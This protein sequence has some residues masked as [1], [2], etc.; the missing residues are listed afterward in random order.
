MVWKAVLQIA[1]TSPGGT[2]APGKPDF[3]PSRCD[4]LQLLMK[5]ST[6]CYYNTYTFL[7][8]TYENRCSCLT[9]NQIS[10]TCLKWYRGSPGSPAEACLIAIL[11]RTFRWKHL[12]T[13]P[14]ASCNAKASMPSSSKLLW[15]VGHFGTSP[16]GCSHVEATLPAPSSLVFLFG[17]KPERNPTPWDVS[18]PD[19]TERSSTT[20]P[21]ALPPAKMSFCF[22]QQG[23]GCCFTAQQGIWRDQ[24]LTR[25]KNSRVL[26]KESTAD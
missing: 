13:E 15:G 21:P 1:H 5:P 4:A 8:T 17:V 2:G 26:S 10:L 6:V 24:Q 20:A 7:L 9:L 22:L 16:M 12:R 19:I 11:P 25:T 23:W 3:I 14:G 18:S